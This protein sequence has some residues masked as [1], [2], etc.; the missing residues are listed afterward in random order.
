MPIYNA[1]LESRSGLPENVKKF[2]NHLITHDYIIISSPEYNGLLTALLKNAIDWA[3]R[4]DQ[5]N[6]STNAF[7][8][9]RFAIMSASPGDGGGQR[10]LDSLRQ[11][12]NN[13]GGNVIQK[14]VSVPAAHQAFDSDGKLMDDKLHNQLDQEI[15]E[16]LQST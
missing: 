9:K 10:S 6:Y 7:K 1:D 4:E 12:L 5:G 8:E 13:L 3:S 16:L 14:T 15:S 11:L 2:R